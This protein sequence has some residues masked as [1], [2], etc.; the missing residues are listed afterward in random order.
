MFVEPLKTLEACVVSKKYEDARKPL[1]T[2]FENV[3]AG[4]AGF[5]GRSDI[6]NVV[7]EKEATRIAS[8]LTTLLTDPDFNPSLAFILEL[9]RFKRA[10][11]QIF[12]TSGFRGT[13]HLPAMFGEHEGKQHTYKRAD[14]LKLFAGISINTMNGLLLNLL[15]KL[16]PKHSLPTLFGFLSEQMV[17]TKR[18]EDI[19]SRLLSLGDHWKD[20]VAQPYTVWTVGPAYMGCS[21]AEAAHKHDI[22]RCFNNVVRTWLGG[23]KI[24]DVQLPAKRA[25]KKRPKLVIFAELYNAGHAMHRCYGPS[26]KALKKSFDTTML[27]ADT[28]LNPEL[29]S[30]AHKV[31]SVEFK[32]TQAQLLIDKVKK[33]NPD[34]IY[35][36]SIGMRFSSIV[37]SSLKL[38]P[39]QT[40]T[41]GHPATSMSDAMDYVIMPDELMRN[42]NTFSEKIMLRPTKPYFTHRTDAQHIAPNIRLDAS[43]VRLAIP[44]WSRKLTPTFLDTCRRIRDLAQTP[45]EFWFFPNAAG[46]LHQAMTRRY[47]D[48]MP[49]D[50]VLPRKGYNQYIRDLNDCD[51]FL[52]SFPFGATNG[53]VDAALQG[54][55]IVNM[56]GDEPHT[57]NDSSLVRDLAQPDWLTT[58]NVDE[59][60][61]A[62]VR[63]VDDP[64]LRVQISR[65]IL[66]GDPGKAFFVEEGQDAEEFDVIMR[67]LYKNHEDIQ[68]SDR[69]CWQYADICAATSSG[70]D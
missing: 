14:L 20:V 68:A 54:L 4:K 34:I 1:K 36:P 12:E 6:V 11:V 70:R 13:D 66:D 37:L 55:P 33:L 28:K 65:N 5:G 62:V 49:L 69:K 63:L 45:V 9:N 35:Y 30:L 17:Y 7:A 53:I 3:E 15:L 48:I 27:I 8:A 58:N 42:E 57:A 19:R 47:A 31:E 24:E 29:K 50:K 56:T 44:A 22:K 2:I 64:G 51:I 26:I 43:P 25:Q 39:I 41:I 16:E 52:S 38:A 32:H 23:Q 61:K 46:L 21:Y 59:Y 60:V 67:H 18:A 10:M 40:M